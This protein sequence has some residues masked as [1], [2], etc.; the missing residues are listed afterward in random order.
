MV[1]AEVPQVQVAAVPTLLQSLLPQPTHHLLCLPHLQVPA[2]VLAV[3]AVLVDLVDLVLVDLVDLD[4]VDLV[5]LGAVA[6]VASS[7]LLLQARF[8]DMWQ[9]LLPSQQSLQHNWRNKAYLSILSFIPINQLV[10]IIVHSSNTQVFLDESVA[11]EWGAVQSTNEIASPV[12]CT[13]AIREMVQQF[14]QR[15]T[16]PSAA[17]WWHGCLFVC[18]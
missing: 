12:I 14:Q 13:S 5:D 3:L 10:N 9:Q 16:D 6:V 4:L 18:L 2:A 7:A 1:C 8:R 17:C 15:Y 11:R